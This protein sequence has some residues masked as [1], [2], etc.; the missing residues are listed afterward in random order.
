MI[1]YKTRATS[2]NV[3]IEMSMLP[4]RH[5]PSSQQ[6]HA[7]APS[8][9]PQNTSPNNQPAAPKRPASSGIQFPQI[10]FQI[11]QLQQTPHAPGGAPR[12]PGR[13]SQAERDC[14]EG[15]GYG[16]CEAKGGSGPGRVSGCHLCDD[17]AYYVGASHDL[18]LISN[19]RHVSSLGYMDQIPA[20][21]SASGIGLVDHY[22]HWRRFPRD[23]NARKLELG[24][25][26]S[27]QE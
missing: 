17:G 16:I 18:R 7:S 23:N 13:G 1:A 3:T 2:T 6:N 9:S 19:A 5:T 21:T 27:V 20:E 26:S 10:N 24:A 4:M 14:C 11:I 15:G 22:D 25:W 8:P 12:Q